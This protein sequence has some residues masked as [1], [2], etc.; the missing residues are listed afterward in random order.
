[1]LQQARKERLSHKP[2]PLPYADDRVRKSRSSSLSMMGELIPAAP[3]VEPATANVL[4]TIAT[5]GRNPERDQEAQAKRV[6]KDRNRALRR[7]ASAELR[8]YCEF[9][10]V[11]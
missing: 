11:T 8:K 2:I 7:R 3:Q 4:R 10:Q 5:R 9:E 6:Q 1:M